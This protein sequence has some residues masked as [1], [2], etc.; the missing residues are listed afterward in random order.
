METTDVMRWIAMYDLGLDNWEPCE[1]FRLG[2]V[3]PH[4]ADSCVSVDSLDMTGEKQWLSKGSWTTQQQQ[5]QQQQDLNT[6]CTDTFEMQHALPAEIFSPPLPLPP[7][8]RPLCQGSGTQPTP[9]VDS[10]ASPPP[11]HLMQASKDRH[12][13]VT[14]VQLYL[15]S[16][17]DKA[18]AC[19]QPYR[20]HH[21]G[22]IMQTANPGGLTCFEYSPPAAECIYYARANATPAGKRTKK[23][24]TKKARFSRA[25]IATPAVTVVQSKNA[26]S[27]TSDAIRRVKTRDACAY[28]SPTR[29]KKVERNP[30]NSL[31][32]SSSDNFLSSENGIAIL[33]ENIV[34]P[35]RGHLPPP[36]P[37]IHSSFLPSPSSPSP[38]SGQLAT[39]SS[40]WS[41]CP[42]TLDESVGC[43]AIVINGSEPFVAEP[44]LLLSNKTMATVLH[45]GHTMNPDPSCR[46]A[47]EQSSTIIPVQL[48]SSED[49]NSVSL[50]Q[51]QSPDDR[52]VN[53]VGCARKDTGLC[54]DQAITAVFGEQSN[55]PLDESGLHQSVIAASDYQNG[56]VG[57]DWDSLAYSADAFDESSLPMDV[58]HDLGIADCTNGNTDSINGN[59]DSTNGNTDSTNGNTDSTNGN[60]DSINGNTDSINGNADSINGNTDST[61]GTSVATDSERGRATPSNEVT[62]ELIPD[63]TNDDDICGDDDEGFASDGNMCCEWEWADKSTQCWSG[64]PLWEG[65]ECGGIVTCCHGDD[66]GEQSLSSVLEHTR[67]IVDYDVM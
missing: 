57:Y 40:L 52:V 7:R 22:G 60:A 33:I 10:V 3:S 2:A 39:P 45:H 34:K 21:K 46:Y 51:T 61:N 50:T 4:E 8:L 27:A 48:E 56:A 32:N 63:C 43:P 54:K 37:L 6:M 66:A 65:A 55:I 18:G 31:P 17:F 15:G 19:Q 41:T 13:G 44:D 12:S 14:G 49:Q 16:S 35:S 47:D 30:Q 9:L 26:S 58:T 42:L 23:S 62:T 20:L 5:Q 64:R 29:R 38:S 11:M 24:T 53:G 67:R 28:G 36:P 25:I 1:P 59:T